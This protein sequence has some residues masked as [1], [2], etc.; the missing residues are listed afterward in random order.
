MRNTLA[1]VILRLLGSRAP[2]W[3]K[4]SKGTDCSKVYAF[5]REVAESLQNDLDHMEL[6]MTTRCGIQTAMPILFQ[7]AK[8]SISCQPPSLPPAALSF[9]QHS[10]QATTYN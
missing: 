4:L 9:L 5:D 2:S 1:T 3:L 7:S 8:C 6:P 10:N